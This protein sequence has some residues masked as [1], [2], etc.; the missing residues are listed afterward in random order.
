MDLELASNY[1]GT[2][3]HWTADLWF[4]M[5]RKPAQCAQ[6][7]VM[8]LRRE[9]GMP[10][11][12]GHFGY[13]LNIDPFEVDVRRHEVFVDRARRQF[14]DGDSLGAQDTLRAAR[15]LRRGPALADVE[16]GVL[17]SA[18]AAEAEDRHASA[19]ELGWDIG[20][21]VD[22]LPVPTEPEVELRRGVLPARRGTQGGATYASVRK[23]LVEELGLEPCP[24]LQ[25]LQAAIL[26][27]DPSLEQNGEH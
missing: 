13:T 2:R 26:A 8:N 18:L 22:D 14:A 4:K 11:G 21:V 20:Q 17:L 3:A 10:I 23:W 15:S 19:L 6:T 16:C 5:P 7:Y 12:T 1:H 25:R 9:F 24:A 27:G